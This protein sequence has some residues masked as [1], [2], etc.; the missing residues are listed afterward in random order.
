MGRSLARLTLLILVL[1]TSSGSFAMLC[2]GPFNT[3]QRNDLYICTFTEPLARST[4]AMLKPY[5]AKDRYLTVSFDGHWLIVQATATEFSDIS[6]VLNQLE[7]AHEEH[8]QSIIET[9]LRQ[10]DPVQRT[11]Y[12]DPRYGV[13]IFTAIRP[14]ISQ[15]GYLTYGEGVLTVTDLMDTHVT[16]EIL[17]A[18][19]ELVY[20]FAEP[21]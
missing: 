12:I 19:L 14:L 16:L 8:Y 18:Q 20:Q 15:H 1:A 11:Y 5:L 3:S 4:S 13:A 17:I 2:Q 9:F 7:G 21:N 10:P 6:L